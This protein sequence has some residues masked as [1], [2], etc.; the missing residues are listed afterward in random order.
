MLNMLSGFLGNKAWLWLGGP[1]LLLLAL[2]GLLFRHIEN[3]NEDRGRLGAELAQAVAG[4]QEMELVLAAM[5]RAQ[6]RSD[7]AVAHRDREQHAVE[8]RRAA[9][10]RQWGLALETSEVF[11]IWAHEPLPLDALRLLLPA[12]GNSGADAAGVGGAAASPVAG[13][14]GP[15]PERH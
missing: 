4:G 14:R 5:R 3:L 12:P 9:L 11:R 8:A 10:R 6:E 7:R 15:D 13:N 1:I 2:A